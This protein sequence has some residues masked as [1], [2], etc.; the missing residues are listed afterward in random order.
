MRADSVFYRD[1]LARIAI[2]MRALHQTVSTAD[3]I[4]VES[5]TRALADVRGHRIPWRCDLID[6]VIGA[7]VKDELASG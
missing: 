7:L 5:T 3:L 4:A 2:H 1:L 6:G